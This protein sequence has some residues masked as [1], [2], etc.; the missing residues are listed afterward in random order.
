MKIFRF[1]VATAIVAIGWYLSYTVYAIALIQPYTNSDMI[2]AAFIFSLIAYAF[3]IV[4]MD[5]DFDESFYVK[6][7][8]TTILLLGGTL[9]FFVFFTM[10]KE[11]YEKD[12]ANASFGKIIDKIGLN[13]EMSK[14]IY[15]NDEQKK[16]FESYHNRNFDDLKN[17]VEIPK[18]LE[19]IS[20][21]KLAQLIVNVKSFD[22]KTVTDT[23]V[24]FMEDNIISDEEYNEINKLI[25]QETV[26]RLEKQKESQH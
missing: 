12:I 3:G 24:K 20:D 2:G 1:L 14:N 11:Y 22:N 26:K 5:L 19:K 25:I 21:E 8:M 18:S 15:L 4:L 16:L 6:F 23:F 17:Y 9:I 7:N 10:N 13:R